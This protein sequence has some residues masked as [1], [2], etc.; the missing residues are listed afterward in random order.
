VGKGKFP[1]DGQEVTFNYIAYNESGSTIDSTY[2][3]GVPANTQLGIN[4]MIP[5][6]EIG[7]KGMQVGGKRRVVVPPELGPPVGG[8]H[9]FTP[10]SHIIRY[11]HVI[12]TSS[13]RHHRVIRC[14]PYP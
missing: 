11:C 5:G 2:R 3:K 4:G 10:A 1:E 14:L 13:T 7:M 8:A 6:F 12:D 9:R